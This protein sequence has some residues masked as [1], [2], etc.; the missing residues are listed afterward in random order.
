MSESS[1]LFY[2]H[3]ILLPC[4][5]D[6]IPVTGSRH[7]AS[8][9]TLPS[10][11]A[12]VQSVQMCRT[13]GPFQKK[14]VRACVRFR[15]LRHQSRKKTA[16]ALIYTWCATAISSVVWIKMTLRNFIWPWNSREFDSFQARIKPETLLLV[17]PALCHV[18][19]VTLLFAAQDGPYSRLWLHND[20]FFYG[21]SFF[22]NCWCHFH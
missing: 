5:S 22:S 1:I 8:V 16:F 15:L 18:I 13:R 6:T 3:I 7:L 9:W 2:L 19:A 17:R 4:L 11:A 21:F 10:A 14:K 20:P 12:R